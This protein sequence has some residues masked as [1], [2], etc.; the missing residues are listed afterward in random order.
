M[1]HGSR[2][3]AVIALL[4]FAGIDASLSGRY[5]FAPSWISSALGLVLLVLVLAPRFARDPRMARLG[6]KMMTFFIALIIVLNATNMIDVVGDVLFHPQGIDAT[7]LIL[8]TLAIWSANV[9]GFSLLYWALDRGGPDARAAHEP[10]KFDFD[11]PAYQDADKVGP[12]W[13]PNFMDYLF[14]GFTTATAFSPTE[15][16]PLS[17]RAKALM[18]LQSLV[19]LITVIVVAARAIGI[20][21]S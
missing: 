8:T 10:A 18:I 17:S 21:P 19:S 14:L 4:A 3:G 1:V 9:A 13:A 16:M 15:A 11:F 6:V 2:L 7:A 5:R 12:G 20:I